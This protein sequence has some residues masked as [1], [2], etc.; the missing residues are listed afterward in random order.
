VGGFVDF[1]QARR[2]DAGIDLRSRKAGMSQ[3][4]LDGAEVAAPAEKMGSE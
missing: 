4:L 1:Q 3:Q 2:V